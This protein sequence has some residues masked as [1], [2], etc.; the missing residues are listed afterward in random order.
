MQHEIAVSVIVPV[1]NTEEFL[2]ECLTSLRRQSLNNFEVLCIDDGSTDNSLEILK[3]F[4][5]LDGRFK[6]IEQENQGLGK[7]R[8]NALEIA[9]GKFIFFLDSDDWI[10]SNTLELLTNKCEK[11][12]LDML[13]FSGKNFDSSTRVEMDNPYWSFNFLPPSFP[14]DCFN[15]R[16]CRDFI[17][18]LPVSSCL[19]MYRKAFLEENDIKFPEGLCF[20]DNLFFLRAIFSA[21]RCG[22][23]KTKLYHR[24]IRQGAITQNWNKHFLDYI[25]ICDKVLD[26][27]KKN[28]QEDIFNKYKSSYIN[29][30]I[31]KFNLFQIEDKLH[32]VSQ[33]TAF[34]NRHGVLFKIQKIT[35]ELKAKRTKTKKISFLG[36]PL[37]KEIKTEVKTRLYLL[38]FPLYSST[39]CKELKRK[40]ILFIKW[41]ERIN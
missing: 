33:F 27:V 7:S 32:Y 37:L 17:T 14:N 22:I 20:E 16:D 10:S 3:K 11:N 39:V 18:S 13:S 15:Y 5:H 30:C 26:W 1:Y 23:E 12:N 29:G 28:C 35:P 31:S 8:N 4:S 2:D 6:V 21:E 25:I 34:L 24:R 36:I 19:T 38:G 9:R 40:R 41:E